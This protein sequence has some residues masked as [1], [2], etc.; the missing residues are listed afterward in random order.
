MLPNPR[1]EKFAQRLAKG[2]T[3][4]SAYAAV[5]DS[6]NPD[7]IRVHSSELA[8]DPHVKARVM[9][10]MLQGGKRAAVDIDR[11]V[12]ELEAMALVDPR[13]LFN[14]SGGIIAPAEWPDDL[15]AAISSIKVKQAAD[16]SMT[17]EIKFWDKNSAIE[18]LGKYH[19]MW[20]D[21]DASTYLP[22]GADFEEVTADTP[23]EIAAEMYR[24]TL[25]LPPPKK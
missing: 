9:E 2:E 7:S 18:K 5:F 6:K 12:Q 20:N 17:Y 23:L 11:I 15:A 22:G 14:A 13:R 4:K 21:A 8:N 16:G 19:G 25:A 24:A 3:A 10:L 1:H